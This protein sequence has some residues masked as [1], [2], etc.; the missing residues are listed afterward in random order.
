MTGRLYSAAATAAIFAFLLAPSAAQA[1]AAGEP[2]GRSVPTSEIHALPE[3]NLLVT[4]AR[5]EAAVTED[6]ALSI[7]VGAVELDGRS[8]IWVELIDGHGEVVYDSEVAPNETHLLPDGRAIVVRSADPQTAVAKADES[9]IVPD[10]GQIVTRRVV[11][12]GDDRTAIEFIE[13]VRAAPDEPM[14]EMARA[15]ESIWDA[16]LAFFSSAAQKVRIAWS[17]LVGTL[18]A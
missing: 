9:R 3:D 7:W 4:L 12:T 6:D 2:H 15:G 8:A 18:P 1:A 16:I 5:P 17:W 11:E 13:D 10:A 14:I